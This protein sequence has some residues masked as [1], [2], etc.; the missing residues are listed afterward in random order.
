MEGEAGAGKLLAAVRSPF[1]VAEIGEAD[2]RRLSHD[3]FSGDSRSVPD[4]DEDE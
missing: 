2:L 1:R 4:S 3:S